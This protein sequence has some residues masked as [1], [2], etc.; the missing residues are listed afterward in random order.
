MDAK[1]PGCKTL[2]NRLLTIAS[3]FLAYSCAVFFF[4]LDVMDRAAPHGVL[5]AAFLVITALSGCA[6]LLPKRKF[7]PTRAPSD[8]RLFYEFLGVYLIFCI[9]LLSSAL[10]VLIWAVYTDSHA[11]ADSFTCLMALPSFAFVAL[12]YHLLRESSLAVRP[13]EYEMARI[14]LEEATLSKSASRW[15]RVLGTR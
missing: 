1:S 5:L 3:V 4:I 9:A 15:S 10:E 6:T 13:S 12:S 14:K 2:C 8:P 11:V 7:S